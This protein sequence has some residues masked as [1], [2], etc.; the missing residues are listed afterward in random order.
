MKRF[1][2]L[3]IGIFLGWVALSAYN[4]ISTGRY[5]E[6][7]VVGFF[8]DDKEGI[9]DE[10]GTEEETRKLTREIDTLSYS[11]SFSSP[12][13][14]LGRFSGGV[15]GGELVE[16]AARSRGSV[17]FI[18]TITEA[19]YRSG[20]WMGWFFGQPEK[21][22]TG[23]GVIYSEDGYLI[24][25]YHV[26]KEAD[27]IEVLYRK[28]KYTATM[29]GHDSSTDIAV[30][31]ISAKKLPAVILGDS[32]QVRLGEWVLAVGNP[33]NLTSTI[34]AG[35]VSAKGR[36]INILK[37]RF[38]IESFIQTDAA[39]NPGNSGG[40]LVNSRGELIGI[41]T[42]IV[43]RTGYYTGYGFAIP[44]NI[45]KKV[46]TD[47]IKYG[48]IQ[49]AYMGVELVDLDEETASAQGLLDLEGL[50]LRRVQP[51]G[52]ADISDLRKG[53]ILIEVGGQKI[54]DR[55]HI[56]ELIANA[57]PGDRLFFKILRKGKVLEKKVTLL[58]QEGTTAVVQRQVIFSEKLGAELE[59]VSKV[60]RDLLEIPHGVRV[61][62]LKSGLLSRMGLPQNFVIIF[63]NK[64]PIKDVEGLEKALIGLR[65]KIVIRGVNHQGERLYFSYYL[66]P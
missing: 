11:S 63:V 17:V 65:G 18:R 46:A 57:Y 48:Q 50:L 55:A 21:I 44:V 33:F 13:S 41:N 27:L 54:R 66:R 1:K 36:N 37:D 59:K 52:A 43:S 12:G 35:I 61:H 23:S 62:R 8:L 29:V 34:T 20:G 4:S 40:A 60:D 53:D 39:I 32:D 51:E 31:K 26:V 6:L 3:V 30:L 45:V 28:R 25:N 14:S 24:T 58:N 9:E 16:A 7:P 38:P 42:A 2:F 22:S 49:K 10:L 47:L 15:V 56:E 5:S 19:E 64:E